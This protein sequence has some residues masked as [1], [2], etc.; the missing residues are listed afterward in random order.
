M[1]RS[2]PR[3]LRFAV[4]GAGMSGIL[5]AI[6]LRKAGHTDIT[7]FEKAG[8]LGGTWRENTYPGVA[9]DV[10]AHLYTYSFEPNPGWSRLLA[11]GDEIQ[12][13]FEHVAKKYDVLP[14]IRFGEEVTSCIYQEDGRWHLQTARG[15]HAAADVVIAATGILHHPRMPEIPGLDTFEGAVFHSARWDHG[16]ALDGRRVGVIGTG[17]TA[18]QI[19]SALSR[20]VAKFS[21]FQ[22]TAQ[23]IFPMENAAYSEAQRQQFGSNPESIETLRE[24]L[25]QMMVSVIADAVI[26]ADSPAVQH[27]ANACLQNLEQNV[28]DPVLKEK[29]RPT[30]RAGCK[31]LIIS[32]DFYDAIQRP[33]SELVTE[34]I[35]RIE[36]TGVRTKDGRLHELD[37][38]I[39]ATGFI[40]DRFVRPA[41]VRGRGGIDLDTA[42]S[43]KP[44][45]Y[46]SVA[47]PGF[48]NLFLLNGPNGPVGN[49]SLI[50]VSEFQLDYI[51]Q[52]LE[53]LREGDLREIGVKAD[54]AEAFERKRVEAARGSIWATGCNSWYLDDQGVPASWPWTF[55]HFAETMAKPRMEAFEDAA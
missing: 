34:A 2:E 28:R 22:R 31:R 19:T 51:L 39:A 55:A 21:L 35:V 20:R 36:P 49:F 38:L 3:S 11:P 53:H 40:A 32:P 13:Y 17:S 43:A 29:L 4:L 46:L 14:L 1:A 54:V 44:V 30:Y 37:V 10:P 52:L 24:E 25:N 50:Q 48:P 5:A 15:T 45:A 16:V 12:K 42:W 23:W 33:T 26:D 47:V 6:R 18:T 8:Q 9:C 41:V 27:L 7:I